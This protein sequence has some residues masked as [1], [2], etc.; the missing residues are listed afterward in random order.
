[1]K[2]KC[3]IA[4]LISIFSLS[5]YAANTPTKKKKQTSLGL[6]LTAQEAY[7]MKMEDKKILFVDIRT[8]AEVAFLGMPTIADVNIP[9]MTVGDWDTWNEKKKNFKLVPNS[10]FLSTLED[11]IKEK[12]LN[13]NSKII[14]ICRS[15]NRSA[16][17]IN[18][19]AQAG[20]KQVYS[21]IDG[22]EGGKI[23]KGE[24]KG[25]R[26]KNGWKNANLPWS[27]KL[28]KDKMTM[29]L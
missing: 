11:K 8:R 7:K 3:I 6:Y 4:I 14:L 26:L 2:N 13:K 25:Q 15:G 21:V 24:H 22:F 1:M 18:L 29:D 9:Y 19:M 28:D 27:Y 12:H 5:C 17:A 16:K 10:G 23:K 20:Y